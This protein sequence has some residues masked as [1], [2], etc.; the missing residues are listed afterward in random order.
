MSEPKFESRLLA[1]AVSVD[2]RARAAWKFLPERAPRGSIWRAD[3]GTAV[4]VQADG[5]AE[6]IGEVPR[7]WSV[8]ADPCGG[9]RRAAR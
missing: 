1:V 3:D 4:I 7:R 8:A 6:E 5:R 9:R 2:P